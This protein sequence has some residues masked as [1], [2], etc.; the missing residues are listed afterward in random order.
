M[1][2][3]IHTLP[4][5][6][7]T[8]TN[9]QSGNLP[10]HTQQYTFCLFVSLS[11]NLPDCL[12]VGR[13]VSYCHYCVLISP[14][15]SPLSLFSILPALHTTYPLSLCQLMHTGLHCSEVGACHGSKHSTESTDMH[16]RASRAEREGEEGEGGRGVGVEGW[17]EGK[18]EE[19]GGEKEQRRVNGEY[20]ESGRQDGG[21]PHCTYTPT[22]SRMFIQMYARMNME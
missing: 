10:V 22:H 14:P 20:V 17:C 16:V 8:H 9:T 21:M 13:S 7:R 15:A 5:L 18:E 2:T 1:Q 4:L 3:D 11:V 12:S 19:G 6:S